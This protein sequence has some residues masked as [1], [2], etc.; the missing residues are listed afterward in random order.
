M[1]YLKCCHKC[2]PLRLISISITFWPAP[3]QRAFF[4]A[5]CMTPGHLILKRFYYSPF[6]NENH[7]LTGT[8]G[9]IQLPDGLQIFTCERPWIGNQPFKS[10]IPPGVYK[11]RKRRSGVVERTSGGEFTQGWEVTD[12][13]G[14]RTFIMIHPAN[15]PHE[16][17]GC[18][19]P[20]LDFGLVRDS[21]AVQSSRDA[22]ILLMAQLE[23][24]SSW[25]L[26]IRDS[27]AEYP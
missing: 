12:V 4:L 6:N 23:S 3:N 9:T 27:F 20:G 16:L 15:W 14:G 22:F 26:E 2:V 1:Y 25:T 24:E 7:P 18:I 10:C 13:P 17:A 5:D 19:A 11:L 8:F 21:L